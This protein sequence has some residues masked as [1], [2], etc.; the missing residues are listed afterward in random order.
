MW[1]SVPFP[2]G[3]SGQTVCPDFV[4]RVMFVAI[5][6]SLV[7]PEAEG[8]VVYSS[9]QWT[10]YTQAAVAGVL[11]VNNSRFLT[12]APRDQSFQGLFHFV[13]RVQC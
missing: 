9:T 8:Y 3:N 11:G 10:Q 1:L 13:W 7:I 12:S 6:N 2:P 5:Q 4:I